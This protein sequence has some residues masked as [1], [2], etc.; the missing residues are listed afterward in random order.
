[1]I[2]PFFSPDWR[3]E[4]LARLDRPFD[5]VVLGGGITGCGV[6]MEAA[7]RGLSVLLLEK[8]DLASGTSSRSSKLLHGGL[9][10]LKQGKLHLT[11]LSCRERDRRL[12]LNPELARPLRFV[13]PVRRGDPV[14][15]WAMGLGLWLY[16]R[17]AE[18]VPGGPREHRRLS[19]DQ[20]RKL[21]P[22][23]GLAPGETA[24]S[25]GDG[26]AD[27]AR[28]TRAVAATGVA[29]G[30]R[31]LLRAEAL[32]LP[33]DARGRISGVVFRDLETGASHTV[34]ARL[35]VN[36]AGVW[37]DRVRER[38]GLS[39]RRLRPSRGSH[40]VFACDRL[41]LSA[42]AAAPSPDDG[43]PVFLIPHPEGVLA[44][45]T[46]L[47]HDGPL[48]DPRPTAEE[49]GYLLRAAQSLFPDRHLDAADV[50]GAFAGLRPIL[51]DRATDPSKASRDEAI[52]EEEGLLSVTGGKLT[53][54]RVMAEEAVD[55]ALRLLDPVP[56]RRSVSAGTALAGR[57]PEDLGERLAAHWQ[58][59]H[60][61]P[62]EVAL[63]A[64]RRL[65]GGAP[66]LPR[67]ARDDRELHPLVDGGDLCAAEVRAHLALGAVLRLEDL[68]LR[69]VRLGMWDPPQAQELAPRL[70]NVF[71]EE[72]G[73][74]ATRWEREEESCARALESWRT[75]YIQTSTTKPQYST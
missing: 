73:W 57:A 65:R 5:L 40:L 56:S 18:R 10:Y 29:A 59:S 22:E 46:D 72:L 4:T 35:V 67:L 68:L 53:T 55:E 33:R 48:D 32:E 25:Y 50:V 41:P 14:P 61:A 63:A 17:F 45:T 28:L 1:M 37:V 58:A 70:R 12:R 27:D 74:D 62:R 23:L 9:R 6:L 16:D 11:R 34:H 21:A 75:P 30:G 51:D 8:G 38:A 31:L 71:R 13:Y 64:A 43:R 42:A 66:W 7:Q 19:R 3:R 24:F 26:V 47:F 36:A 49:A 2:S 69:R 44:G 39:G 15:A 54:W 52:W 60:G 20:A